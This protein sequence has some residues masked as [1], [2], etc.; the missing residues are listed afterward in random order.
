MNGVAA[1]LR[2][3]PRPIAFVL[4]FL[5]AV[6]AGAA[7]APVV[8]AIDTSRSLSADDLRRVTSAVGDVMVALPAGTPAGLLRFADSP[9]WME[10]PGVTPAEVGAA[11]AELRPEGRF[12][13]LHDAV[14]EAAQALPAGGVVLLVSDGRDENSATTI[15][16]IARLCEQRGV[17]L[18]TAAAGARRDERVLRRLS[19]LTGGEYLGSIAELDS[20]GAA[21]KL[22]AAARAAESPASPTAAAPGAARP[23]QVEEVE[24]GDEKDEEKKKK[25]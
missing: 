24:L 11:L 14:F 8:V 19:L 18:F 12:T 10:R 5:A 2:F 21:G 9:Q 1:V 22:G 7:P 4:L 23:A 3:S 6:A 25:E 15:D 17:R 16:D 13:L 20:A